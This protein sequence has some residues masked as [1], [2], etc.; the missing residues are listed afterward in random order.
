MDMLLLYPSLSVSITVQRTDLRTV[1]KIGIIHQILAVQA[2]FFDKAEVIPRQRHACTAVEGHVAVGSCPGEREDV[3][4]W[5][6]ADALLAPSFRRA[7]ISE[8]K[9]AYDALKGIIG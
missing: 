9:T 5:I 3:S 8:Q 2:D 7:A 6:V 1:C 4:V